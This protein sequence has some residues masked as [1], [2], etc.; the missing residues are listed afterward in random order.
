M[1]HTQHAAREKVRLVVDEA[2]HGGPDKPGNLIKSNNLQVAGTRTRV[3]P[4]CATY[5]TPTR[6]TLVQEWTL[7]IPDCTVGESKP[8]GS[9]AIYSN[10]EYGV[11]IHRN[12]M[13]VLV[14]LRTGASQYTLHKLHVCTLHNTA[15]RCNSTAQHSTA[16]TS[17]LIEP[18]LCTGTQSVGS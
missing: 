11:M 3:K 2:K 16:R 9:G 1:L 4:R 6:G 14:Y 7:D 10:A 18:A 15:A 5:P 8:S 17:A 13:Y 12:F